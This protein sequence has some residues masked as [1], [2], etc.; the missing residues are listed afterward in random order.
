MV[1]PG[2][3]FY[4]YV[5]IYISWTDQDM[6]RVSGM[7]LSCSDLYAW[8]WIVDVIF[9]YIHIYTPVYYLH[10]PLSTHSLPKKITKRSVLFVAWIGARS[11]AKS[12]SM[13]RIKPGTTRPRAYIL[14]NLHRSPYL[15]MILGGGV[16]YHGNLRGPPQC[17]PPQEIRPY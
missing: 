16:K 1:V 10:H 14:R 15:L 13:K 12:C 3:R 8:I 4:T 11:L 2:R 17:P 7:H 5:Y 9:T 6:N